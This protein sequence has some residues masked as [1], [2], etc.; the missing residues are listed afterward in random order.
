[1]IINNGKTF[2]K[3]IKFDFSI[4]IFLIYTG[5]EHICESFDK[6]RINLFVELIIIHVIFVRRKI[7]ADIMP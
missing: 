2:Q 6:F 5:L 7:H 3:I 4:Y 1:M